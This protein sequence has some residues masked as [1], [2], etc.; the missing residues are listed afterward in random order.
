MRSM[1]WGRPNC[2]LTWFRIPTAVL[3]S[4]INLTRTGAR[5]GKPSTRLLVNRKRPRNVNAHTGEQKR[6]SAAG[7]H[8]LPCRALLAVVDVATAV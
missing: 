8:L 3:C 2:C 4:E 7:G 5:C 6:K 1:A